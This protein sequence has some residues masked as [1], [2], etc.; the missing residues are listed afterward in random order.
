MRGVYLIVNA[1]V[2]V[3]RRWLQRELFIAPSRERSDPQRI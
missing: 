3:L 1:G 2:W